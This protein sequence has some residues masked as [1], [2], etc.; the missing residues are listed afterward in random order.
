MPHLVKVQE[1]FKAQGLI[2][3]AGHCQDV[4]KDKVCA[5]CQSKHVNYT[6]IS[7]GRVAGDTSNGI[8]HAFL[9]DASGKCVKEGHPEELTKEIEK[10]IESEPHW[11][12]GGRKLAAPGVVKVADGLKAGKPFGWALDQLTGLLK[13]PDEKTK[14]EASFLVDQIDAEG[15]RRLDDAKAAE[16][17]DALGAQ[18]AYED[19]KV[20]FKKS[21][22]EKKAEARLKELK[23]D[24]AFQAEI[25]A[26][27]I[28]AQIEDQC[29]QLIPV[30]GKI[31]LE[32]NPN[33]PI[34]QNV[35][36]LV[37]KLKA[38]HA[39]ARCTKRCLEAIKGYGF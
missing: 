21:D 39:D 30:D 11:I 22:F 33:V 34:A 31:N 10:L 37:A 36:M 27:K 35:N 9:F 15:T 12:T 2:I 8:P 4:P 1:Q 3:V 7:G 38:K 13:K 25:A 24:K 14:D 17:D 20:T 32:Y 16:D 29:S 19:L 28:V 6:I 18:M 26:G 5:L 23:K